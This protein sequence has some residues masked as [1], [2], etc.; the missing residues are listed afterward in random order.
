[1]EDYEQIRIL[2]DLGF[3]YNPEDYHPTYLKILS[4]AHLIKRSHEQ[5]DMQTG[6]NK[7]GAPNARKR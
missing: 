3:R 1:M 5:K 4:I 7:P 6:G 2:K